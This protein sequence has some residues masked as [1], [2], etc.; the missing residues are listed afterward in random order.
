M[1]LLS[2][3]RPRIPPFNN[4]LLQPADFDRPVYL[5]GAPLVTKVLVRQLSKML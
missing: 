1:I 4:P 3:L 2:A 5:A